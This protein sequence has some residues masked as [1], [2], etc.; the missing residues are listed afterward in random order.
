VTELHLTDVRYQC[1]TALMMLGG[2][3]WMLGYACEGELSDVL[4]RD[5]WTRCE[6]YLFARP[7]AG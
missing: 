6:P 1:S 5:L 4:L 3:W 2:R 7:K